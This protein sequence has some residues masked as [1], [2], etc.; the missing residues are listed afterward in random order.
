MP[1]TAPAEIGDALFGSGRAFGNDSLWV[2]GLGEGG[3]IRAD[4]SFVQSNGSIGWKFGWWRIVPGQLTITGRRLDGPAPPLGSSVP[5]GYGPQ[6]FQASG[7]DFMTE[8]CWE[9]TGRLGHAELTF[10]TFVEVR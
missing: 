6:G 2:G 1:I 7:V 4:P 10:V 8:G 5:D 9:V 3:V